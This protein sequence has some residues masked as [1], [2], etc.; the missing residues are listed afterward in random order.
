MQLKRAAFAGSWY[1]GDRQQCR[2][3]IEGFLRDLDKKGAGRKEISLPEN[4]VGGIVPHAGWIYSGHI[5]C[6]VFAT[7]ALSE[8]SED[9]AANRRTDAPPITSVDTIVLFGVHM[10]ASSP[11][12]VLCAGAVDTPLG[13]I[14][15]DKVLTDTVYKDLASAGENIQTLQPSR[16]PE[17]NTLEVQFPFIRYFFP[18]AQLFICAVPPSDMAE[19]AG[20]AVVDA[21][22][23]LR[24]RIIAVGSTDMT[25][26]GPRFGFEPA[27]SGKAGLD[28]V[29]REN[30]ACAIRVLQTM[31]TADIIHQGVTRHNMCCSGA[32]CAAAAAAKKMGAIKGVCLDYATSFEQSRAADFVGY[33]GVV[34]GS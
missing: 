23:R 10:H 3:A 19:K 27:G 11:A 18:E 4:S 9:T 6:R 32:A 29:T 33:C 1:P 34:F 5:A 26:Y 22:G 20:H 7:L 17:E 2:S 8:K 25:H 15:V 28:W 31:D 14:P 12:M 16:F 30:D 13:E 24:K 21:A